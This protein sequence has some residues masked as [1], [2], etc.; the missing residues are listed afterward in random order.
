MNL[1]KHPTSRHVGPILYTKGMAHHRRQSMTASF[2]GTPLGRF[3][4]GIFRHSKMDKPPL[5]TTM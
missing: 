2:A 3:L 1:P 4:M 5:T